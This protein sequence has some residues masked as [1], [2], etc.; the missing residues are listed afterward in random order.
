MEE[1][2]RRKLYRIL[3]LKSA[4]A[5]FIHLDQPDST[6]RGLSSYL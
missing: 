5:S 4:D 1:A 3:Q 2:Q 6:A